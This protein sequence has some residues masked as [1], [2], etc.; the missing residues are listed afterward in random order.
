MAT[1]PARL[2]ETIAALAVLRYDHAEIRD[3]LVTNPAA[4][5]VI[6]QSVQAHVRA[7]VAC[8]PRPTPARIHPAVDTAAMTDAE[9][10]ASYK[11]TALG[12]DLRFFLRFRMSDA[13]R[14]RAEAI[15][16]PTARDVAS[17]REAWRTERLAK[18]RAA[19][20]PAIG[21]EEWH[22]QCAGQRPIDTEPSTSDT[23]AELC[24]TAGTLAGAGGVSS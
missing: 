18:D 22:R 12:E 2:Q 4:A 16:K 20:I 9:L 21:T 13:L 23:D 24:G 8:A 15:A 7:L 14:E 6:L 5:A 17:L 19:G 10:Y 3:G 1:N 11:R